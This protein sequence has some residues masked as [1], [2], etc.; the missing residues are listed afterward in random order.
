MSHHAVHRRGSRPMTRS[1]PRLNQRSKVSLYANP[2]HRTTC[3]T[4]NKAFGQLI[5]AIEDDPGGGVHVS[6][7]FLTTMITIVRSRRAGKP[8]GAAR[9]S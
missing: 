7:R 9:C 6:G 4:R 5:V 2:A 3:Q 1:S 8:S